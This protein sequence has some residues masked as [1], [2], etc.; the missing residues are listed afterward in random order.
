MTNNRVFTWL[1]FTRTDFLMQTVEWDN[2]LSWQ[3]ITP[4]RSPHPCH[5]TLQYRLYPAVQTIPAFHLN[6]THPLLILP[7]T[8]YN[9]D[10][11]CFFDVTPTLITDIPTY[12]QVYCYTYISARVL[13][14]PLLYLVIFVSCRSDLE[15]RTWI[16]QFSRLVQSNF[17]P[18]RHLVTSVYVKLP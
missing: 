16:Y 18:A 4:R 3:P 10:V 13:D 5:N 15:L 2:W 9:H 7:D 14:V 17:W 8:S 11:T 12:L 1:T 6:Q